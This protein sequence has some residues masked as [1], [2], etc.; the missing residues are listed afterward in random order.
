MADSCNSIHPGQTI[1]WD[2]NPMKSGQIG[3]L[4]IQ[5]DTQ[6]IQFVDGEEVIEKPLTTGEVYR[7]YSFKEDYLGV[8]GGFYVKRDENSSYRTPSKQKLQDL[9]CATV[10]PAEETVQGDTKDQ[11]TPPADNENQPSNPSISADNNNQQTDS[12]ISGDT[13]EQRSVPSTPA[14]QSINLGPQ[15]YNLSTIASK[16]GM[17]NNGNA[18]LYMILHGTPTSLAVIDL[19]TNQVRSVHPLENSTSAWGLDVDSQGTLWI[20]GTSSPQLYSY[21]PNTDELT[22]HGM[23]PNNPSDTSIQDLAVNNQYVYGTTA[24]G[25]NVFAYNKITGKTEFISSAGYRKQIAKSV[26]VDEKNTFLYTSSGS[27]ANLVKWDLSS[28][29]KRRTSFITEDDVNDTY[30]EKI[31]VIDDDLVAVKF[32][33]ST[34]A[35]L[36]QKSTGTYLQEFKADSRGF[37]AK[38]SQRNEFYY[39]YNGSFYAYN[40][41]TNTVRNTYASLP[42]QK[43]ALSLDFVRLKEN[44]SQSILTG[45][46]DNNGTY[47]LY[48]PLTNELKIKSVTPKAQPVNLYLL[49][50]GPNK[51][52]L[53]A[54][55]FMTGGLTQYNPVENK[56]IQLNGVSQI[57]SALFFNNKLYAGAYPNAR[58]LELIPNESWENTSVR[59]LISL[60]SYGQERITAL[61]GYNQHLFAGTYP[62]D[63]NKGGLLL[64]YDVNTGY[65]QVYEDYVTGHSIITLL[66]DQ[67]YIYGGSS[68]H[69]NYQKSATPAKFFRFDPQHPDQK[70]Y[71]ELPVRATMVMSLMKGQDGDIWGAAD[72]TIFAYH[73]ETNTFRTVKLLDLISGRFGNANLLWGKDG[74]IYVTIE[75][76][77]YKINPAD[78]SYELLVEKG[79]YQL[80]EDEN[81]TIYYK[82]G[83][84]LYQYK[85]TK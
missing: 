55:G 78:L 1:Y 56:S 64:D 10:S 28:T 70:E 57:D 58:L 47:Y 24:Y 60:E 52:Y 42:R 46:I 2:G 27:N 35:K 65:Y 4:T 37:S 62:Q 69:A 79:A 76:H 16:A 19:N 43:N 7:I 20:G 72:G 5:K 75:G 63:S 49:F 9:L 11:A 25:A 3:E 14:I 77:L 53:Y 31:K 83:A 33:P 48:N 68:I 29:P 44:P 23:I 39:T 17:D 21:N 84:N 51:K 22:D 15:V 71:I 74:F 6:L 36:F 13:I 32:F 73:P 67:S 59:Q 26:A 54:N 61:T 81:G 82:D 45:L 30:A 40:L 66:S 34:R 85:V 50:S 18:Y 80:A 41:S 12:A 38:D 8:G